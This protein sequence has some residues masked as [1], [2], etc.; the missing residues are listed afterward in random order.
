MNTGQNV[1]CIY[2]ANCADGFTAAWALRKALPHATFHGAVH[3]EPPP[4][5]KGMDVIIVDFSYKLPVILDMAQ[6]AKSILILDHHKSARDDILRDQSPVVNASN[7]P[8]YSWEEYLATLEE[9]QKENNREAKIYALFDMSRSGAMITWDFFF[10]VMSPPT[11]LQYVQDRDLWNFELANTRTV[12]A[13]VFS[14]EYTFDNWEYLMCVKGAYLEDLII[15]GEAIERK[16]HKDVAEI[17]KLTRRRKLFF[18]P[19]HIKYNVWVA[20]VPHTYSSDA[21]HL[22]CGIPF[23]NGDMPDFAICYYDTPYRR[24]YS[25]RSVG[26]FDVSV[27]AARRGGGGHKNAAGYSVSLDEV[28]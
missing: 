10:P 27:I 3:S 26:D 20:N 2:H 11:V 23:H 6:E 28:R 25:L 19:S 24:F 12:M 5:I 8:Q 15:A 9:D 21:G 14:Y 18:G 17:V 13:A 1:I 7:W 22:M 16:H 4:E